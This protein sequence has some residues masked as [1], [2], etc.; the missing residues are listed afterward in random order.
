[1]NKK[2]KFVGIAAA[3]LLTVS[4]VV[5]SATSNVAS[6]ATYLSEADR[7]SYFTYNGERYNGQL[8]NGSGVEIS[9]KKITLQ[10]LLDKAKSIVK[11]HP[12][13]SSQKFL[14]TTSDLYEQ[15]TRAGISVT[16][17]DPSGEITIPDKDFSIVLEGTDP[18]EKLG[19]SSVVIPFHPVADTDSPVISINYTQNGVDV[20]N[21]VQN[22]I[23]EIAQNSKFDPTDFVGSDGTRYTFSATA[24]SDSKTSVKVS[25]DDNKVDTSK[26]GSHYQVTLTAT[27]SEGKESKATYTVL[28]KPAGSYRI[29]NNTGANYINYYIYTPKTNAINSA[30]ATISNGTQLY[31]GNKTVIIN[32][33]SYTQFSQKSQ[34]DADSNSDAYLKTSYLVSDQQ[35]PEVVT[36]TIMHKALVYDSGGGSKFRKLSAYSQVEVNAETVTIKGQEYYKIADRPDYIK[37]SNIDGTSRTLKHNAYIYATSKKRANRTVLKKGTKVITYGGSYKF[38]NGKKYYRIEGATKTNKRYVKVVNF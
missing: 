21:V 19:N 10:E 37:A 9:T 8:N 18:I 31:I 4:P 17:N 7:T 20:K 32:G 24:S 6:A 14:T 28:V 13:N 26:A 30:G 22:Q 35:K 29:Y 38:K 36:K 12:G 33:V 5:A 25:G 23:L 3:T 2:I 16:K 27:N 1:M 11:F 34:S 15:L